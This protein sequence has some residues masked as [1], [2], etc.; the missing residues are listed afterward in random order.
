VLNV[1]GVT[2][3][4]TGQ[5]IGQKLGAI[6]SGL[7]P[8][9]TSWRASGNGDLW[10]YTITPVRDPQAFAA[11]I[12]FGTVTS[13]QGRTI[14]VSVAPGSL[15]SSADAATGPPPDAPAPPRLGPRIGPRR[16]PFRRFGRR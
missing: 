13:V 10:R 4:E 14:N 15:A 6:A 9:P 1:S 5:V 3:R 16:P 11:G 12:S 2:D 7:Q 8:G